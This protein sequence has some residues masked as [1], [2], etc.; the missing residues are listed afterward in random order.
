VE[1]IAQFILEGLA[2]LWDWIRGRRR[3]RRQDEHH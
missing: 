2:E 1:V 3:K